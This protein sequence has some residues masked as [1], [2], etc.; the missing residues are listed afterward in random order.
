M[1][2]ISILIIGVSGKLEN[3]LYFTQINVTIDL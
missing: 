3:E 1:I 2:V